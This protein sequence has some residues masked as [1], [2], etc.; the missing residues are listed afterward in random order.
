MLFVAIF[1]VILGLVFIITGIRG[2]NKSMR[3]MGI[4]FMI[5]AFG[6]GMVT[7]LAYSAF[8]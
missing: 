2:G 3:D 7:F 8:S 4:I 5:A 1:L 6:A